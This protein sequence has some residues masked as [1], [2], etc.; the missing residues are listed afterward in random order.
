[1]D[2]VK[3]LL[4]FLNTNW[5][6]ILVCAGFVVGIATQTVNYYSKTKEQKIEIAKNQIQQIILKLISDAEL[7][8][9]DWN[10]AGS[11]KRSQVI[12]EIYDEY[13]ILNKVL[14]QN[15]LISWIDNEIN[16]SLKTLREIV[17]E[18]NESKNG[19]GN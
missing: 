17:K 1:M 3:N 14:V 16:N 4:E 7:D 12:K 19:E 2:G 9:N 13:P 11:I 8:W 10:K 5:T 6:T 15:E 18:N